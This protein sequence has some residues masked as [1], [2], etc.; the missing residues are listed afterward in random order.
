MTD[1]FPPSEQRGA[2][3]EGLLSSTKN[4]DRSRI[5]DE[6]FEAGG[7]MVDSSVTTGFTSVG[8]VRGV[9]CKEALGGAEAVGVSCKLESDNGWGA[10]RSN[11]DADQSQW[12]ERE[13]EML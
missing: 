1:R 12:V 7:G 10:V 2:K 6:R 9:A 5:A 3:R 4:F 13:P 8:L 11:V